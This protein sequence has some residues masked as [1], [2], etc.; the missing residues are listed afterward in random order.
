M[1]RR[2]GHVEPARHRGDR[3]A[4][5]ERAFMGG[6]VDAPRHARRRP[7]GRRRRAPR[8]APRR[9]A[10]RWPR[11]CGRQRSP[12][13]AR[14][15]TSGVAEHGERGR[16]IGE[17]RR[18]AAGSP[19]RPA[20]ASARRVFS[21]RSISA[22][23]RA[24]GGTAGGW[25][26]PPAR[27]SP[28]RAAIAAA[29]RAVPADQPAPGD[30]AD[31]VRARQAQPVERARRGVTCRRRSGARCRRAGGG[32]CSRWRKNTIAASSEGKERRSGSRRGTAA[33]TGAAAKAASP[34]SEEKRRHGGDRD[35]DKEGKKPD[36]PGGGEQ[37]AEARWRRP[38][39]REIASQTGNIWPRS[40]RSRPRAAGKGPSRR[41]A[42]RTADGALGAVQQQR[43]RR[44]L[45]AAG[46]QH[47]GGADIARADRADVAEAGG[48]GEQ[49]AEG[50]R[51]E[52]VADS[53]RR[54]RG[55]RSPEH[56]PSRLPGAEHAAFQRRGRR[57]ACSAPCRAAARLPPARPAR[58]GTGRDRPARR[59]A[60]RP[61]RAPSSRAGALGQ[62]PDR[63][64]ERQGPAVHLRERH[65]EQR[66]EPGAA[67]RG[68]GEGQALVVG[69]AR[70]V[71]GGDGVDRAVGERRHDRLPVRLRRAAAGRVW[72]RCGNR[73]SRSR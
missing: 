46:A 65:G 3:P 2:V 1:L 14:R 45:L 19:A 27:A 12:P 43:R 36:R 70:L 31:A 67:G 39:R 5:R 20:R 52:Q 51:A 21:S 48:A 35:P 44:Q 41:A 18:G 64:G 15:S 30:R 33:R 62:Q 7:A 26:R 9:S 13:R 10:G 23:A 66:R 57:R 68:L 58:D 72:R 69:V 49:Q 11:R 60:S 32:Y 24:R 63:A 34:A 17:L 61:H 28:G 8:P 37:H 71:V 55:R 42:S 40:R 59:G 53:K 47:V 6:A 73:R 16:R 22:S 29:G 38:C 54:G 56:P 25:L 4:G 50:D